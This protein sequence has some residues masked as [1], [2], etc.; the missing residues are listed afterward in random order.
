[1]WWSL[2]FCGSQGGFK[3]H[4]AVRALT[5][6]PD[7]DFHYVRLYFQCKSL[8]DTG[9]FTPYRSHTKS[10]WNMLCT[11]QTNPTVC[12]TVRLQ[13]SNW[14]EDDTMKETR[15]HRW[16]EEIMLT[17]SAQH[18]KHETLHWVL[19]LT[20]QLHF[21]QTLRDEEGMGGLMSRCYTSMFYFWVSGKNQWY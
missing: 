8:G 21:S 11:V 9:S 6:S 5:H 19:K 18:D 4:D 14:Q 3:T 13:W 1:M 16:E 7:E 2:T 12:G 15:Q 20:A 10:L 17:T